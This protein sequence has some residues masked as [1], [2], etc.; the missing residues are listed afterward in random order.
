VYLSTTNLFFLKSLRLCWKPCGD[1]DES[2]NHIVHLL[3]ESSI[4][5]LLIQTMLFLYLLWACDAIVLVFFYW[6]FI[7]TCKRVHS[8]L[9]LWKHLSETIGRSPFI[10][11]SLYSIWFVIINTFIK[12]IFVSTLT[13][14]QINISLAEA[15][16]KM[17]AYAKFMKELLKKSEKS[18]KEK[19]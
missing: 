12:K 10:K 3:V 11:L 15:L 2:I 6:V 17:S 19:Q 13:S 18:W 16:E 5:T 14:L 1:D 8:C 7:C 9:L 4:N